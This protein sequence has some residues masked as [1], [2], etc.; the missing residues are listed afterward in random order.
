MKPKWF[1]GLT[2]GCSGTLKSLPFNKIYVPKYFKLTTFD[3]FLRW[4]MSTYEEISE[5]KVQVNKNREYIY[6]NWQ[7]W[8]QI[9]P[10]ST[11]ENA[12][13]LYIFIAPT[14]NLKVMKFKS[15]AACS[16]K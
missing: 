9:L 1:R 11:T 6:I 4:E 15:Y 7:W 14:D 8:K 10:E 16:E 3:N 12:T 2:G 13:Q 5:S